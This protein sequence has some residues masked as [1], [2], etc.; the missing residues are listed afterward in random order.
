MT[1]YLTA[2][3]TVMAVTVVL[4]GVA[5]KGRRD[6]SMKVAFSVLITYTVLMPIAGGDSFDVK[7]PEIEI[8]PSIAVDEYRRVCEDAFCDGIGRMISEKYGLVREDILVRAEGFDFESMSAERVVV[9]LC[10]R[11]A[12]ADRYSIEK[13][14]SDEG[15]GRC[16]VEI[17]LG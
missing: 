14:V 2:I 7:L 8:D 6:I 13:Y 5:Y 9:I 17:R 12:M 3:A 1:E 15:L 10:G 4:G 11:A 16:E